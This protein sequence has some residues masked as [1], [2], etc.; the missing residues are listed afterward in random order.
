MNWN[1]F[2]SPVAYVGGSVAVTTLTTGGVFW[3]QLQDDGTNIV[4]RW[5]SNGKSWSQAGTTPRGTYLTTTPGGDRMGLFIS[6]FSAAAIV[7][8]L[9]YAET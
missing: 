9:S 6:P 2:S 4:G 3:L 5:S 1:T 8:V 7:E